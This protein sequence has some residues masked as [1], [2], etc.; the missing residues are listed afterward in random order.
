MTC[1]IFWKVKPYGFMLPFGKRI[2]TM[3]NYILFSNIFSK[4][5]PLVTPYRDR[6]VEEL[7]DFVEL[8]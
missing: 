3:C 4:Q 1:S 6:R 5:I 2:P 7:V 8:L